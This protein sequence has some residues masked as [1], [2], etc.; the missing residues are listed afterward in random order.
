MNSNQLE[1]KF[2]K[3]GLAKK[4]DKLEEL[5]ASIEESLKKLETLKPINY[6]ENEVV[7]VLKQIA[8]NQAKLSGI[9]SHIIKYVYREKR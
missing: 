6:H 8:R 4:L 5:Q 9:T 3:Q 1:P 7:E 2:V